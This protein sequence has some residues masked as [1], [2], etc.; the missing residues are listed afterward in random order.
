MRSVFQIVPVPAVSDNGHSFDQVLFYG[1]EMS[2]ILFD[3]L[4]FCIV[5]LIWQNY[6]LDGVIVFL[7]ISVSLEPLEKKRDFAC[8]VSVIFRSFSAFSVSGF[9]SAQESFGRLLPGQIG[10]GGGGGFDG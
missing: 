8:D 10:G 7:I 6:F 2:L 9:C 1:N 3:T 5:D 4:L